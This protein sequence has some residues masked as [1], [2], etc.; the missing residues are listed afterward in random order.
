MAARASGQGMRGDETPLNSAAPVMRWFGARDEVAADAAAGERFVSG[1][2]V[3]VAGQ[4]GAAGSAMIA[5]PG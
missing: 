3:G 1:D 2:G 5:T 4:G